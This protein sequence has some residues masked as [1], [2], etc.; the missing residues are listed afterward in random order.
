MVLLWPW[1]TIDS[2]SLSRYF[3]FF[4][5]WKRTAARGSQHLMPLLSEL[6]SGP[7]PRKSCCGLL[8]STGWDNLRQFERSS[9]AAPKPA[10]QCTTCNWLTHTD[11]IRPTYKTQLNGSWMGHFW[12][13]DSLI[14]LQ[15]FPTWRM[16]F[17][18]SSQ[19]L[20]DFGSI[21]KWCVSLAKAASFPSCLQLSS[22]VFSLSMPFQSTA[23]LSFSRPCLW[24]NP[25]RLEAEV[26]HGGVGTLD[27]L[28]SLEVWWSM[29]VLQVRMRKG[30]GGVG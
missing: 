21:D 20:I 27:S 5:Q 17:W 25:I 18:Q 12:I 1:A 22:D 9:K 16:A 19:L 29:K 10:Q 6:S 2:L 7:C 30:Q 14:R 11:R 3:C 4:V 23:F 24:M 8:P 28:D 15:R 13:W 26:K